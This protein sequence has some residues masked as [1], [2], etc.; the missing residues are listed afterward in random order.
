MLNSR[1]CRPRLQKTELALRTALRDL[2]KWLLFELGAG[3]YTRKLA[4]GPEADLR[5]DFLLFL[6]PAP[7]TRVLDVGCGPGHLARELARRGCQV[8]ATDRGVRL[9]RIARSLARREKVSVQ[10]ERVPGARQPFPDG[11]FDLVLATTVLYWVERP[12]AVLAEMV[13]LTRPGGTVATL[14]PHASMS[15][16]A[17]RDYCSRHALHPR[18]ARKLITWAQASE[19][20][21]RRDEA[22]LRGFLAAAGLTS[23]V[24]ERRLDGMVWFA[25]GSKQGG[26]DAGRQG[27]KEVGKS[28]EL[29]TDN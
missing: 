13:R 27:S 15:V 29:T 3:Y 4:S 19:R 11:A 1:I 26:S 6:A 24:L 23:L 2:G 14:D 18:D 10:F 21:I 9:I 28:R 8:T 25:R 20:S 16:A 5:S 7:G 17:I 22:S 12:E